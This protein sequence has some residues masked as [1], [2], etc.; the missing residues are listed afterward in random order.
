VLIES[1]IPALRGTKA[2]N[3]RLLLGYLSLKGPSLPYDAFKDLKKERHYKEN[4]YPTVYRRIKD[5]VKNGYLMEAG[6]RSTKRGKQTE[7]TQYSITWKGFVASLAIEDVRNKIIDA[8]ER[9]LEN[10]NFELMKGTGLY[11]SDFYP[12]I[13]KIIDTIFSKSQIEAIVTIIFKAYLESA[14]PSLDNVNDI[15]GIGN[16]IWIIQIAQRAMSEIK[17]LPEGEAI[18]VMDILGLLDDPNILHIAQSILPQLSNNF[19]EG[20]ENQ[21]RFLVHTPSK[22]GTILQG[23]EP[24]D[25]PSLRVKEFLERELA[26][27]YFTLEVKE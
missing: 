9:N 7:E 2:Q 13:R 19:R 23:L 1:K 6:E 8:V 27:D 10:L 21:Y 24:E 4:Q 5:L 26:K 20:L 22:I 17:E 18:P 14:T 12:T 25:K 15:S 3:N 11:L 16:W